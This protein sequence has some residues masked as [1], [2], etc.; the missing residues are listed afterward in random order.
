MCVGDFYFVSYISTTFF[1]HLSKFL[2]ISITLLPDD[3]RG[4]IKLSG[5]KPCHLL[6]ID[7]YHI[8]SATYI[9]YNCFQM[10]FIFFF[11]V[12]YAQYR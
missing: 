2:A 4:C 12:I 5:M 9:Y 8:F 10:V 6:Y 7:N 3:Y 1:L 11:T